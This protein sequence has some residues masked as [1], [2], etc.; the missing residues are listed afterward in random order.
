[1]NCNR[2]EDFYITFFSN[3]VLYHSKKQKRA[4]ALKFRFSKQ[5]GKHPQREA[6]PGQLFRRLCDGTRCDGYSRSVPTHASVISAHAGSCVSCVSTTYESIGPRKRTLNPEG[7]IYRQCI[8]EGL[9]TRSSLQLCKQTRK[10]GMGESAEPPGQKVLKL[11]WGRGTERPWSGRRG[12]PEG[13]PGTPHLA[14]PAS[15]HGGRDVPRFARLIAWVAE[16]RRIWMLK[17]I[18]C[19]H[20]LSC[21][22]TAE[23]TLK[24][25]TKL[26]C[27]NVCGMHRSFAKSGLSF[28]IWFWGFFLTVPAPTYKPPWH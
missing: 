5:W 17:S 9:S 7:E 27:E 26:K 8:S 28:F 6:F 16:E 4:Q 20:A 2:P 18:S 19:Q 25:A 12:K 13:P 3:I 10:R 14:E 21:N 24:S 1:M 22:R 11:L 23:E 15:A